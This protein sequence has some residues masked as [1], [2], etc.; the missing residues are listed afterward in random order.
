MYDEY[1]RRLKIR[2]RLMD[3]SAVLLVVLIVTLVF[4]FL[5]AVFSFEY[6]TKSKPTTISIFSDEVW[7]LRD[8]IAIA[9]QHIDTIQKNNSLVAAAKTSGFQNNVVALNESMKMT[10]GRL[11]ELAKSV[12]ENQGKILDSYLTEKRILFVF[13]GLFVA[14]LVKLFSGLYKYNAYTKAHH[15]AIFDALDLSLVG[16]EGNERIDVKRFQEMVAT[17]SVKHLQIDQ[18]GSLLEGLMPKKEKSDA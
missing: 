8:S 7:R 10:S 12:Y 5:G 4:G 15:A 13:C 1:R 17:L 14:Y 3:I 11:D 9:E 2:I 16:K 6:L 18:G